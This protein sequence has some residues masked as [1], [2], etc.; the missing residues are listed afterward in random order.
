M[1]RYLPVKRTSRAKKE[2]KT[3]EKRRQS[4]K[5]QIKALLDKLIIQISFYLYVID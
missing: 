1:T 3:K 5:A 4:S 2:K